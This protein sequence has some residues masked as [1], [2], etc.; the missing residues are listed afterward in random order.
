MVPNI[1][2]PAICCA[3]IWS[4]IL[5]GYCDQKDHYDDKKD[6]RRGDVSL[7][8]L[9]ISCTVKAGYGVNDDPNE[10]EVEVGHP[11]QALAVTVSRVR[12]MAGQQVPHQADALTLDVSVLLSQ[13]VVKV[14]QAETDQEMLSPEL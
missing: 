14:G 13:G 1:A 9:D 7:C 5:Q 6:L 12:V 8:S 3:V 4:M 10:R 2:L 11:G